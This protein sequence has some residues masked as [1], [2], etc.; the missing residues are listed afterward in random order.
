MRV[1]AEHAEEGGRTRWPERAGGSQK[2][3]SPGS[4]GFSEKSEDFQRRRMAEGR[5][6]EFQSERGGRCRKEQLLGVKENM[7]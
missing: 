6:E 2:S 4:P 3:Q 7:G 5:E 1:K